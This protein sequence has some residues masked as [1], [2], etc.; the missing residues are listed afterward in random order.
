ML[1]FGH[2]KGG[3][4]LR[5]LGVDWGRVR[6]GVAVS[7][8]TA[9]LA[10]PLA[11]VSGVSRASAATEVARLAAREGAGILVV[12]LPLSGDGTEGESARAARAF[13]G[14]LGS[15]SGLPVVLWDERFSSLKADRLGRSSGNHVDRDQAAACVMLKSFLDDRRK[16][17]NA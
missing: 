4:I 8:E 1:I 12:G 10:R 5:F 17:G 13:A 3:S 15:A 14:V 9:L 2:G 16:K 7:D 11:T 6:I